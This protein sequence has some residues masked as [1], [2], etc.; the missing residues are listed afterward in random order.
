MFFILSQIISLLGLIIFVLSIQKSE[1][2]KI[3]LWQSVSFFMYSLSYFILNAYTG[4]AIYLLNIVRNITFYI[5]EK[6]GKN[7]KYTSGLFIIFCICIGVIQ[8]ENF[9]DVLPII[10]FIINIVSIMQKNITKLKAG[11]I[12]ASSVWI[13]YDTSTGAYIVGISEVII[14]FA[15]INSILKEAYKINI[16]KKIQQ[17]IKYCIVKKRIKHG[18][19]KLIGE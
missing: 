15:S 13:I 10:V 7:T 8:F 16:L 14:I 17:R 2:S 12:I 3:L 4:M 18:S 1:K 5:L 6:R 9:Y 19:I 11:Q